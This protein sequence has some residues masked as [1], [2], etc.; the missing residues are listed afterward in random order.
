MSN[1][2]AENAIRSVLSRID[3]A[4]R[5]KNFDG[6][7]ECF[8]EEA[9]IVGPNYAQ[10]AVGRKAC[11]ESYREFACNA[12]VL[13]YLESKHKLRKWQDTAVYTF[14]WQM[15]YARDQGP[16]RESG[17]DQLVLGRNGTDWRVLFRYIHFVPSK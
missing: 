15:T 1:T 5:A 10:Y 4:W 17:T 8:D 9:V 3:A 7:E 11:A 14:A 6:L 12:A 16:Q 2:S 13:E